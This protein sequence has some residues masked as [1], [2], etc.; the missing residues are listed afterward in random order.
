MML[1]RD[2]IELLQIS[3]SR[4]PELVDPARRLPAP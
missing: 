3:P 4:V 1:L 2:G